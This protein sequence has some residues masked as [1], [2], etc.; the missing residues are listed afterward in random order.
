MAKTG[1]KTPVN[2]L[3][4]LPISP[5]SATIEERTST[6]EQG[7]PSSNLGSLILILSKRIL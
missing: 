2:P 7:V 5:S 4:N 6:I 1:S 3:N